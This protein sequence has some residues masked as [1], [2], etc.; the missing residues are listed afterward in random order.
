[1]E[2]E[3]HYPVPSKNSGGVLQKYET[4]NTNAVRNQ[5]LEFSYGY[6][7]NIRIHIPRPFFE[8]FPGPSQ[9][10]LMFLR[11][12]RGRLVQEILTSCEKAFSTQNPSR[13]FVGEL[14]PVGGVSVWNSRSPPSRSGSPRSEDS[15]RRSMIRWAGQVRV[16]PGIGLKGPLADGFS[17]TKHR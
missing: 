17:W 16:N 4:M 7:C 1:M 11:E 8:L 14:H 15:D 13:S 10:A 3:S 12:P 6:C 5:W 2:Y 9:R